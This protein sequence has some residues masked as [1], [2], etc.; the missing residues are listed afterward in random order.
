VSFPSVTRL[1]EGLLAG[2]TPDR[3]NTRLLTPVRVHFAAQFGPRGLTPFIPP[4]VDPATPSAPASLEATIRHWLETPDP[5][6]LVLV[7]QDA[8]GSEA[9]LAWF[10]NAL[11]SVPTP[12]ATAAVPLE[13]DL[14]QMLL[15]EQRGRSL[16]RIKLAS[17]ALEQRL[18]IQPSPSQ[19]E[20]DLRSGALVL[21]VTDFDRV[22]EWVGEAGATRM[23]EAELKDVQEVRKDGYEPGSVAVVVRRGESAPRD[24]RIRVPYEI[25]IET[26][27]GKQLRSAD[28]ELTKIDGMWK[29]VRVGIA[30]QPR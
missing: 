22:A 30:P 2:L 11:A 20:A 6:T 3:V 28:I 21:V 5:S 17:Q 14:L 23:L 12:G 24:E 29:V 25:E 19:I 15:P 18:S 27:A 8:A 26:E 7:G 13:L 1:P 10:A 9:A 16:S 4:A